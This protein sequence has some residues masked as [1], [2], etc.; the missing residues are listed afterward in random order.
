MS[1]SEHS[2]LNKFIVT[3]LKISLTGLFMFP[4]LPYSVSGFCVLLFVLFAF[5]KFLTSQKIKI[6]RSN[7]LILL[8]FSSIPIIYVSELFFAEYV[9][10]VWS[11]AQRKMGLLFIPLGF[12]LLSFSENTIKW[13]VYLNIFILSVT[14]LMFYSLIYILIFGLNQQYIESGGFAYGFR[15]FVEEISGLHPT[16]FGMML[17]FSALYFINVILKLKHLKLLI[18]YCLVSLLILVFLMLLA[19]RIALLAFLVGI[20]IIGIGRLKSVKTQLIFL[21]SISSVLTISI[22]TLPSIRERVEEIFVDDNNSTSVR[23]V[24]Y[25]C[26]TDLLKENW[27]IGCSVENTQEMLNDCYKEKGTNL[28]MQSYNSHNE[29]F[30]L[31]LTKGIF[32]LLAF[33]VLLIVLFIRARTNMEFILFL[34]IFTIVCL[35]ENLLERQMGVFFFALFGAYFV[36]LGPKLKTINNID[37]QIK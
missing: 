12:Y 9:D 2:L 36:F 3:G 20:L 27:L 21:V 35:T 30:N 26:S 1:L 29:Y 33:L 22:F 14:G 34:C 13:K 32:V 11:I 7:T 15:T 10:Y 6:D 37:I 17:C 23:H 16:Y 5:L 4:I 18:F 8:L 25:S 24:I 31:I 28:F 19:S